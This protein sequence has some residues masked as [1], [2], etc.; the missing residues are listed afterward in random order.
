MIIQ[1]SASILSNWDNCETLFHAS[2]GC[3][4]KTSGTRLPLREAIFW[5]GWLHQ[6]GFPA[7]RHP[8]FLPGLCHQ[9][10]EDNPSCCN[11]IY[12]FWDDSPISHYIVSSWSTPS[13]I[14]M[15][16]VRRLS[17]DALFLS[18]SPIYAVPRSL[19][20]VIV[21]VILYLGRQF[22]LGWWWR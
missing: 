6:E 2:A 21:S 5:S 22:F 4:F 12:Q 8:W 14:E 7:R 19:H 16:R 15:I 10:A 3:P 18:S 9:S 1:L 17:T 20:L 11:H 13:T